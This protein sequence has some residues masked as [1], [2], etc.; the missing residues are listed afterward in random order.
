VNRFD[1]EESGAYSGGYLFYIRCG[2]DIIQVPAKAY[3]RLDRCVLVV[4]Y[5]HN[6]RLS[7]QCFFY[8]AAG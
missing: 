1:S 6:L 3:K 8:P 5:S 7:G 2:E 4:K